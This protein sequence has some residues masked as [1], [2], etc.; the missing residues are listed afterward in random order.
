MAQHDEA[1]GNDDDN[2]HPDLQPHGEFLPDEHGVEV[3]LHNVQVLLV[4]EHVMG[5]GEDAQGD[6][7]QVLQHSLLLAVE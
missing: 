4:F 6:D 2:S 1:R 5:G 7:A 3:F